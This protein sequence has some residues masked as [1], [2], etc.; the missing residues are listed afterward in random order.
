[1]NGGFSQE[2][3]FSTAISYQSSLSMGE[4]QER[5]S[6]RRRDGK[7]VMEK[8][9]QR[10]A[11]EVAALEHVSIHQGRAEPPLVKWQVSTARAPQD[12]SLF[13]FSSS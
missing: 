11:A 6:I 13:S 9:G 1:M 7:G 10:K 4:R 5:V 2:G 3:S 8:V 12:G